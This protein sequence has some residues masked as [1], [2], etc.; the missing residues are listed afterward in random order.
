MYSLNLYH[1]GDHCEPGI[2]INDILN[3]K[4]KTL[5]MLGVYSFNN[6]ISY[7]ND[8]DYEKIYD[9]KYLQII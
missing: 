8:N 1:L 4:T 5:F 9:K 3:I 6:I 2:I 7:L